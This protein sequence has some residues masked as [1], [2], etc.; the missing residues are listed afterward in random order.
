MVVYNVSVK[1]NTVIAAE[2]LSWMRIHHI[3]KV[4][5]TGSFHKCRI[6]KLDFKEDD[7]ITFILQ[8]EAISMEDLTKYMI[9][10]AP[11]LQKEHI[12]RYANQ[13][14]AFRT[15]LEVIEELFPTQS[16]S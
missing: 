11:A 13:F 16:K 7:G 3:P 6:S 4:L 9:H 1:I 5:S 15:I 14:V 12:E 10:H 2:W 8:Y